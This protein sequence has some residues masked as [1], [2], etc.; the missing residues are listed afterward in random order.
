MSTLKTYVAPMWKKWSSKPNESSGLFDES[1]STEEYSAFIIWLLSNK[2]PSPEE[3]K[4]QHSLLWLSKTSPQVFEKYWIWT[5]KPR[6]INL[7]IANLWVALNKIIGSNWRIARRDKIPNQMQPISDLDGDQY[8]IQKT[9]RG[10][11]ITFKANRNA[12]PPRPMDVTKVEPRDYCTFVTLTTYVEDATED[13]QK[14]ILEQF[15]CM[16]SLASSESSSLN[17]ANSYSKPSF[18]LWLMIA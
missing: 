1:I 7:P 5:P 8:S 13:A 2:S 17:F 15:H 9:D 3:Q 6:I 10:E 18:P 16:I 4:G 14:K 12:S 11:M